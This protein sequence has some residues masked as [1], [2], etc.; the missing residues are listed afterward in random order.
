MTHDQAELFLKTLFA[1]G[2][3]AAALGTIAA[4]LI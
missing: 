2:W 4:Y 3:K 1:F